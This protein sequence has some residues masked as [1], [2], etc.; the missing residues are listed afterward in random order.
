MIMADE[1]YQANIYNNSKPFVSFRKVLK[2]MQEQSTKFK[3]VQL[4]SFHSTSKG[5]IGECGKRGGYFEAIGFPADVRAEFYKLASISLC[6][7]VIGQLTV[8]LMVNPPSKSDASYSQYTKEV[9]DIYESLKRRA[10]KVTTA[11]RSLEGVTCNES[12]GAM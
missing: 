3:D 12:E 8:G 6:P 9:A 4:V 7:N 2:Q 5:M 10:Q 1:V 11:L